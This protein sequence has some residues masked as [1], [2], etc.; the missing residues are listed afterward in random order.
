M[1]KEDLFNGYCSTVVGH[2]ADFYNDL[3][4]M[5]EVVE[6]LM[7]S[8]FIN[9][10]GEL[11]LYFQEGHSVDIKQAFRDFVISKMEKADER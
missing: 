5:A 4:F 1:N 9:C 7:D 3:N 11:S 6:K 8:D 2:G 10:M